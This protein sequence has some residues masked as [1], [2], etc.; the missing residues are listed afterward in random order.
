MSTVD[1]IFN[2][3]TCLYLAVVFFIKI[4]EFLQSPVEMGPSNASPGRLRRKKRSGIT[5]KSDTR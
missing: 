3:V 2:I 5:K 4:F 1:F